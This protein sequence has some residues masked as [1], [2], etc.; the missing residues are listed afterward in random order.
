MRLRPCVLPVLAAVLLVACGA[1]RISGT[2]I[3]DTAD[4][5]AVLDSVDEYRKAAER[6]DA[7]T[8]MGLVS[9]LYF[10]DAGTSDPVDDMDYGQLRKSLP[11]DYKKLAAVKLDMQVRQVTVDGDRA[12]VELLFEG[13]YRVTTPKRE[14]AKQ[15]SDVQRMTLHREG[16][17]WKITSGL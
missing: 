4:T 3:L 2:D 6:R 12:L 5:R 9:P 10:D 7:E 1:K 11:A 15:I 13:H 14:V 16:G 8:V 17:A